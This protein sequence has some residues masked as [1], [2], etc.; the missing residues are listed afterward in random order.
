MNKKK[1]KEKKKKKEVEKV[2]QE[3]IGAEE[4][5]FKKR[6]GDLSRHSQKK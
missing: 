6:Y 3:P 1:T 4:K 2:E 5:T